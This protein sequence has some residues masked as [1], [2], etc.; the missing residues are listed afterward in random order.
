MQQLK[1]NI[2]WKEVASSS[3][4]LRNMFRK[5]NRFL[6]HRTQN[7]LLIEAILAFL[8]DFDFSLSFRKV[9]TIL[10]KKPTN[11]LE[12]IIH[13]VSNLFQHQ[14]DLDHLA[15]EY[16]QILALFPFSDATTTIFFPAFDQV[17]KEMGTFQS[18]AATYE[19]NLS[20]LTELWPI[21]A[22]Q[23]VNLSVLQTNVNH[24]PFT[25]FLARWYLNQ[26]PNSFSFFSYQKALDL[27]TDQY[28]EHF[29][30]A[31]QTNNYTN[32][33][34]FVLL[35]L[36]KYTTTDQITRLV[37]EQLLN[38]KRIALADHQLAFLFMI[39]YHRLS[40]F[41]WKKFQAHA[42]FVSTKQHIIRNLNTFLKYRL[43]K[44]SF[45][46]KRKFYQQTPFL[47]TFQKDLRY[48]E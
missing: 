38:Q 36:D 24:F 17:L 5:T 21:I 6:P 25:K 19:K 9:Q 47:K 3:K 43:L 12:K 11:R 14:T 45:I 40:F 32:L 10:S 28:N 35:A 15:S 30:K 2:N 18:L 27:V 29:L 33:I 44:A 31:R 39:I 1:F 7:R 26:Q 23:I 42:N 20:N 22:V 34:Q 46:K 13:K 41:D 4:N 48:Y 37:S 16:D 8:N